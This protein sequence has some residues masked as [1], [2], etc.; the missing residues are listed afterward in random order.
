[1][2]HTLWTSDRKTKEE[3]ES[4]TKTVLNETN[5][6]VLMRLKKI[7]QQKRKELENS[8][9]SLSNYDSPN[10]DYKQAHTNGL[11]QGLKNV[12][13]LLTFIKD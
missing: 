2:L 10:W 6:I 9:L 8:E 13:E 12:E 4:F 5:N 1:M 11:R 3:R 7:I